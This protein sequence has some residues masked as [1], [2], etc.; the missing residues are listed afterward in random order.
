MG[1]LLIGSFWILLALVPRAFSNRND[2]AHRLYVTGHSM[3]G[4]GALLA[5]TSHRALDKH[6]YG[7]VSTLY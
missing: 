1:K 2:L 7:T 6:G 4:A 5:A 3:G